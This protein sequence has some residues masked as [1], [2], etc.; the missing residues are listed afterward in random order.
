[1]N[2]PM[3]AHA[4]ESYEAFASF[5]DE[6]NHRYLYR[7]WTAT[8]LGRAEA[9]GLPGRRLLDVACG[10]GL[11][12]VT[13]LERGFEVTGTDISPAMLARARAR[14]GAST[15]LIVA[16]MR[17]LPVLGE[18]DLIWAVNGPLNYLLGPDELVASLLAM[19]RNLA[20][21]GVILW[22]MSTFATFRDLWAAGRRRQHEGRSYTWRG[23]GGEPAPGQ[24]Y[25]AE[26]G[27][28]EAPSHRHRQRHFTAAEVLGAISAARL[29]CVELSGESGGELSRPLDEDRH[30]AAV[31]VCRARSAATAG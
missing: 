26:V 1:M 6:F 21:G 5:Y 19:R 14:L 13:P 8:L 12:S 24:V 11:S 10:T 30:T 15:D 25:E 31:Y 4:R 23:L 3:S 29:T 9:V 7:T 17:T 18:F 20:P 27:H 16:D 28:D 22:D 2:D